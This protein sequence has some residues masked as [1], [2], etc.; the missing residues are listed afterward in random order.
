MKSFF[1]EILITLAMAV[2]IC[3]GFRVSLQTFGIFMTSMEPNFHEGQRLLVNKI[4]YVFGEPQR[5]DVVIFHA[6]NNG[7]DYIKRVIGL[8]G[9]T[10]EIRSR[11]VYVNG[12]R[13]DEPYIMD[14][15]TYTLDKMTVPP[16]EYFVLGD[17]RNNSNDSHRGWT[18]PRED[19]VGKAW[20]STW[21]PDTWGVVPTYPLNEQLTAS[22]VK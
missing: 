2:I 16:D 3:V 4:A 15:P 21:P 7:G 22:M 19:I 18:V 8:P 14:P 11:A 6:P 10:V 5:G 12:K 9:D 20:L 13:L 1:K 17:N